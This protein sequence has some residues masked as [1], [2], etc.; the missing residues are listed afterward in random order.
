[1]RGN[2]GVRSGEVIR[3]LVILVVV[4]EGRFEDAGK[5]GESRGFKDLFRFR[6]SFFL[7]IFGDVLFKPQ[8]NSCSDFA[9]MFRY[10]QYV[11]K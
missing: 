1:M 4:V 6:H 8:I 2:G 9:L 7:G 10:T 5:F 11:F 3:M